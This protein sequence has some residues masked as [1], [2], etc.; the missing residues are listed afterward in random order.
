MRVTSG[1][2]SVSSTIGAAP[3]A[4][5]CANSTSSCPRER[6][7]ASAWSACSN[8]VSKAA[9][10][11]VDPARP[12]ATGAPVVSLSRSSRSLS[13]VARP[14]DV[15]SGRNSAHSPPSVS[16]T[17][18][19]RRMLLG[20]PMAH[21][22]RVAGGADQDQ[23]APGSDEQVLDAIPERVAGQ[24]RPI[25]RARHDQGRP[26]WR[27]RGGLRLRPG[28]GR[29]DRC[30][31]AVAELLHAQHQLARIDRLGYV[32]VGADAQPGQ[33]IVD[34]AAAGQE[35]E[36]DAGGVGMPLELPRR[37]EAVL[38]R[39]L[40]VEQDDRRLDRLGLGK[41]LAAL[42][43]DR[44][45][46]AGA[47]QQPRHQVVLVLV[48]VGDE[49][50]LAGLDGHGLG[51]SLG[52]DGGALV[53]ERA[54]DVG[55]QPARRRLVEAGT[56]IGRRQRLERGGVLGDLQELGRA[57]PADQPVGGLTASRAGRRR[58]RSQPTRSSPSGLRTGRGSWR[59]SD[60]GPPR[61]L[62]EPQPLRG[63]ALP[64]GVAL[65]RMRSAVRAARGWLER[66]PLAWPR[67]G[68]RSAG[69]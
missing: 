16:P 18:S 53:G 12:A 31:D 58:R 15:S 21:R 4:P 61:R 56:G 43:H 63:Q 60:G 37:R 59:R 22:H 68:R 67:R 41:H 69:S 29:R 45:L 19:R 25:R 51:R 5:A 13:R 9:P 8:S 27:R 23:R 10:G 66:C 20:E 42:R 34:G 1:S 3:A 57:G 36:R 17:R 24:P 38:I 14:D 48:V 26:G 65:K 30:R 54:P 47:V 44:D 28:R 32:V 64:R 55:Q 6:A 35:H 50:R 33:P 52:R 62:P 46:E 40:H 11:A 49:H 7:C 39:H 2:S